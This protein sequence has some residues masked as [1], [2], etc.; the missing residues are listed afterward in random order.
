M[1][2]IIAISLTLVAVGFLAVWINLPGVA[3]DLTS[4]LTQWRHTTNGW[5]RVCSL[6]DGIT[7]RISSSLTPTNGPHPAIVSLLTGLLATLSLAAFTPFKQPPKKTTSKRD[8][9]PDKPTVFCDW[10]NNPNLK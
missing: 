7:G 4:P 2:W 3:G 1:R 9:R 5:E 10:I 6:A 8:G